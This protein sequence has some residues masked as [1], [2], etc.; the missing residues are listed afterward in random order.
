ME[1][2]SDTPRLALRLKFLACSLCHEESPERPPHISGKIH[3]KR[4]L[5]VPQHADTSFINAASWS[6]P[7][8]GAILLWQLLQWGATIN[9]YLFLFNVFFPMYPM[10]SAKILVC[11]MQLC[12]A[13]AVTSAKTLVYLSVP[14]AFF[15]IYRAVRGQGGGQGFMQGLTAYMA[16]MCLMEAYKIWTLMK[17][18]QLHTHYLFELARSDTTGDGNTRRFNTSGL[19]DAEPARRPARGGGG[20]QHSNYVLFHG[21]GDRLGADAGSHG[22]PPQLEKK[23]QLSSGSLAAAAPGQRTMSGVLPGGGAAAGAGGPAPAAGG[24][25]RSGFLDR[26]EKQEK[27]NAKSVRELAEERAAAA[28]AANGQSGE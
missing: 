28:E 13:K 5:P 20:G 22:T 23:K 15:L 26:L 10:D 25:V 19:D 11:S 24:T 2:T 27:N 3:Q 21:D 16:I 4:T 9:L 12:G 7:G 1:P 18:R 17:K 6:L 8:A 14:M